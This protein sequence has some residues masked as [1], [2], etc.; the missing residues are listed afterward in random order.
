MSSFLVAPLG[1]APFHSRPI[2]HGAAKSRTSQESLPGEWLHDFENRSVLH[3]IMLPATGKHPS[4][5]FPSSPSAA[6]WTGHP[7]PVRCPVWATEPLWIGC[8][9]ADRVSPAVYGAASAFLLSSPVSLSLFV[10]MCLLGSSFSPFHPLL[11]D[12]AWAFL[13]LS[14]HASASP[15]LGGSPLPAVRFFSRFFDCQLAGDGVY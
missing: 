10:R 7:S 8:H 4:G 6:E 3:G 2:H 11:R 14:L 12:S 9:P 13:P 5:K 1:V 15:C